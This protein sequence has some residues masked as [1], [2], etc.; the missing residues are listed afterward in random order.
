MP[1]CIPFGNGFIFI[2][3]NDL[4]EAPLS[5]HP[6]KIKEITNITDTTGTTEK[7][8]QPRDSNKP[9]EKGDMKAYTQVNTLNL[10]FRHKMLIL[11]MLCFGA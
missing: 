3:F 4:L 9:S 2:K 5:M 10:Q 1:N 11:N 6:N 7:I 8:C